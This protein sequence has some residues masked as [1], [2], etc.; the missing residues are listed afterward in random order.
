MLPA[1]LRRTD[2]I[3]QLIP[4]LYLKEICTNEFGETVQALV[5]EHATGLSPNVI[6][7]LLP[8]VTGSMLAIEKRLPY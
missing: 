1:Y 7:R 6:V 8:M 2:A 4:W 3:E 5:G